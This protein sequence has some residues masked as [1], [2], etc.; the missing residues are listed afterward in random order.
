MIDVS[1]GFQGFRYVD[2]SVEARQDQ[3]HAVESPMRFTLKWQIS[4]T[5]G[6]DDRKCTPPHECRSSVVNLLY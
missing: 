3:G 6:Y 4:R 5:W 2:V 1:A